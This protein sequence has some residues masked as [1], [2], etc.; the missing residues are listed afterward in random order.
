MIR[1]SVF[2]FLIIILTT[3]LCSSQAFIKTADLFQ[4]DGGSGK[5][6]IYQSQSVDTL[7]SR[8]IL[9]HKKLR[10]LEE[11]TQGMEGFRI[12]IYYS[13][14]RNA[15]E[16]S[17]KARARFINKFPDILSYAGFQEPGYFVVRAG[18]FRTK[19]EAYKYLVLIRNEFP[20]AY[21]VPAIINY[22]DLIKN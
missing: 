8:Y 14:V 11:N 10:T 15:K 13:S 7:I 22:P 9:A 3:G 5:L 4:R 6:T 16:E 12:Q 18:D 19:T 2:S 20:N 1:Q 17:A 21:P